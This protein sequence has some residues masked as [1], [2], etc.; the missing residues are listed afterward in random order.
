M[1]DTLPVGGFNLS[2]PRDYEIRKMVSCDY[3]SSEE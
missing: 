3:C 1:E 2:A